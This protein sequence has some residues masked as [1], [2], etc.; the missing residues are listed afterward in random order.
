M[1]PYT[2]FKT[3]RAAGDK[4]NEG[5]DKDIRSRQIDELIRQSETARQEV[6]GANSDEDSKNFYNLFE[7]TRRMPT[8][9]PRIAAPQLQLLLL[10]EAAEVTD[11]NV[12]VYIHKKD[13]RDKD[14]EKA[15]QE[16]WRQEFFNLQ[17][18]MAQIYAQFSGT[19]WLQ[20]GIDPYA[21]KGKG[22]VWLRARLQK[23]VH[24]D[25]ISPWPSDWTWQ[26]IEDEMYLDEAKKRFLHAENIKR[27]TAK[28]ENLGA[29]AAGQLEM[30][31]GPMS[32]TLR[33]IS[34]G[35]QSLNDGPTKIRTLY[36]LDRSTRD[37][38]SEEEVIFI[39]HNLPVP[40]QLPVYPNGRMIVD[41]EGTILADGDAWLPLGELW[42]ALPVWAVPPWDTVWCPSPMKY[43]KSLQ[44][45]AE[46]QM[47][48]TYENARRLNQG[49]LV[50]NEQTGLTANSV[51]GLP[52]EIVVI[53]ANSPPGGIEV[54]YP[55]AFPA[56][57]IS[58][59][60]AY[61]ALQKELRGQTPARQGNM[62]PGNVGPDLFESAVAQSQSGTR[63]TARL[64]SWSVQKVSELLF[65]VMSKG[66]TDQRNF[67]V[68]DKVI[69]WEPVSA[70]DEYEI[71]MDED[72]IRPMSQGALRNMAIELKKAGLIDVKHALDWM[73]VPDSDEIADGITEELKLAAIAKGIK[74]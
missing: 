49:F 15:F 62:N 63:L 73:G 65:F 26:V 2:V 31:S 71:R 33:G 25:P 37:L 61:L 68:K 17:L 24:V 55:P 29:P 12:R 69:K 19:S 66:Y 28:S 36:C 44:D 38:K 11:N 56:Q 42:P 18:L 40:D 47:T 4:Q 67:L 6:Y 13:E 59:P 57:M 27:T 74:K 20:A 23:G 50:I 8:F 46:Q 58:L 21:R 7:R 41:A 35:D 14:R 60:Q 64:F 43:T 10:Q 72:S 3:Q 22:N 70:E 54:K 30:P 1:A 45:A 53:A 9:R 52:G 34:S 32:V 16:H 48:N 51:G 5:S 39:K